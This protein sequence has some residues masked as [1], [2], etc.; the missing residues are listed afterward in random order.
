M[1]DQ[2]NQNRKVSWTIFVWA[3]GIMFI[4][5]G[6]GFSTIVA[7]NGKIEKYDDGLTE[8]R[9]DIGTI[10]NDVSWVK[11]ALESNQAQIKK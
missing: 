6:V 5:L 3:L 7:L 10:K 8:M 2:N 11:K 4:V 1:L 9:V